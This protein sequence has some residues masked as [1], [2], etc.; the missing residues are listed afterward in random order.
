VQVVGALDCGPKTLN[1]IGAVAFAPE[2]DASV[3]VIDAAAIA[4]PTVPVAGALTDS[5][6]LALPTA[7]VCATGAAGFQFASPG[8]VALTMHV[9][10]AVKAS[11]APFGPPDV[12]TVGL[13][14]PNVTARPELAVALAV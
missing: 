6:G 14:V 12:Q 9:P 3:A 5:V 10:T 1:V 13:P 2:L 7:K 4:V 8:C 11:V